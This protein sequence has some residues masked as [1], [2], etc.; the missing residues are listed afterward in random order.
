M[1]SPRRSR[2]TMEPGQRPPARSRLAQRQSRLVRSRLA[3]RQ[4]LRLAAAIATAIAASIACRAITRPMAG[5]TAIAASA[6]GF[7]LEFDPVRLRT[8]G[9]TILIITACRRPTARIAGCAITMMRCWSIS[10][11][12]QSSIRSTTSSG[13]AR[14]A[15]TGLGR[16]PGPCLLPRCT[17]IRRRHGIAQHQTAVAASTSRKRIGRGRY[18]AARGQSA[19]C[20]A[21]Q[22]DA[23]QIYYPPRFSRPR[24]MPALIDVIDANRRPSTL[25]VLGARSRISAPARAATWIAGRPTSAR[26]TK[27]SRRCSASTRTMARRCRASAMPPA[28]NSAPHHDYFHES[29]DYWQRDEARTAASAPGRR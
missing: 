19:R 3:A 8:T 10:T 13:K 26:S 2:R 11:P 24:A 28:S 7:R 6:I 5:T 23:A 20:S 15:R 18:Q 16:L 27:R 4:P 29:E 14:R 9:S 21:A 22:T 1:G 25:L 17:Q 12:A